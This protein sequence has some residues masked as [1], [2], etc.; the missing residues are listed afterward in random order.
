MERLN[1]GKDRLFDGKVKKLL[2]IGQTRE[3][4]AKEAEECGF[5]VYYAVRY[6]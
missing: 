5:T 4:I 1:N 3:K 6:I 2:L